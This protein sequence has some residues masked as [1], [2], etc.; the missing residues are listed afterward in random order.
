MVKVAVITTHI[1]TLMQQYTHVGQCIGSQTV[2]WNGDKTRGC[3]WCRM[4]IDIQ[5]KV[6][7]EG[8]VGK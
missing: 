7:H 4:A 1:G 3:G 5:R 6:A 8:T 2:G